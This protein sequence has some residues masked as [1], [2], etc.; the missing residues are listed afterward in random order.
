MNI[1]DFIETQ[2]Q[3][4]EHLDDRSKAA[5]LLNSVNQRILENRSSLYNR[6]T[7]VIEMFKPLNIPENFLVELL[8][9]YIHTGSFELVIMI[10]NH[11]DSLIF[12]DIKKK[13]Q[14]TFKY[15]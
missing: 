14:G 5:A 4:Y 8:K 6:K 13:L 9:F 3:T 11:H 2:C 7:D 10:E 12:E 1:I 15:R